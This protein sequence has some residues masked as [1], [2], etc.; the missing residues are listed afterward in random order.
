MRFSAGATSERSRVVDWLACF[1]RARMEPSTSGALREWM[2][3]AGP[4]ATTSWRL[5]GR[6]GA[7]PHPLYPPINQ[8]PQ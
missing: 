4:S 1:L 6:R 2:G 7:P 8:L 3:W 5:A